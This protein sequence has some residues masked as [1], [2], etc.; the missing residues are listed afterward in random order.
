MIY[1][2][3]KVI[4][5]ISLRL[6]FQKM[7]IEGKENLPFRKPCII[8]SNHPNTLLD[9]LVIA[10]LLR[11]QIYFLANGSLFDTPLKSK[12][13][14]NL[15]MIPIYRKQDMQKLGKRIGNRGVFLR[16]FDFLRNKKTILIFPEGTSFN[17]RR[18]R[19]IKTGAARIAFG[20][21]AEQD[22]N[23]DLQIIPIG[24]N[25]TN[26]TQFFGNIYVKIGTPITLKQYQKQYQE[27]RKK[28]IQELTTEI[29]QNL[30]NKIIITKNQEED[31]FLKQVETIY[32]TR[33]S[34]S[35]HLSPSNVK[36]DFI[37]TQTIVEKIQQFTRQ[38]LASKQEENERKIIQLK[39][40]LTD[41]FEILEAQKIAHKAIEKAE[42]SLHLTQQ[43]SIKL[44]KILLG[45]PFFLYGFLN[46]FI[47]YWIPAKVADKTVK[48][49][50]F[51][52]SVVLVI[53]V[54]VFST[55]YLL[56]S[57]L[58][59]LFSA[60]PFY[61]FLYVLSLIPSGFFALF[62]QTEL[63]KVLHLWRLTRMPK[64]IARK[65]LI[66]QKQIFKILDQV[67]A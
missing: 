14:Y 28:A 19:D 9:P 15:N 50:E 57:V 31:D 62:Y 59:Y 7:H 44:L 43:I 23:L 27:N 10:N 42:I 60:S 1:N 18:L 58:F 30:E 67:C 13:M 6:F 63:I 5:Q 33:L 65:L 3:L 11:Q 22:F 51:R 56:Q 41:Y 36:E 48:E 53:G 4:V 29:T 64:S 38:D 40:Y 20:A 32:K 66:S 39:K 47:P 26:P 17:E 24:L 35:L 61:T 37:L 2:F 8:V 45:F 52:S 25:Y 49:I 16:C 12:F 34:K 55:F 46:N 21:E 54:V